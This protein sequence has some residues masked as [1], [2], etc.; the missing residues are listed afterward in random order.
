MAC[1]SFARPWPPERKMDHRWINLEERKEAERRKRRR[2]FYLILLI[3]LFIVGITYLEVHLP[4]LKDQVPIGGNVLFFTIINVNLILFLLLIFLVI[5]NL[6]KLMLE[7]KRRLLGS[8]LKTKLSLAFIFLSLVP[9]LLLFFTSA[10]FITRSVESWFSSQVERSLQ[11]S[12]EVAQLYYRDFAKYAVHHSKR[13]GVALPRKGK[14]K[15]VLERKRK[16]YGLDWVGVFD[17]K[18]KLLTHVSS[19]DLPYVTS[20]PEDFLAEVFKGKEASWVSPFYTS[21]MIWGGSVAGRGRAVVVGYY[22]PQNLVGKMKEIS[23]AF[24]NYRQSQALK[25]PLITNYLLVLLLIT[26][27]IIF[28]ATWFGFRLAKEIT[29]PIER[30]A[31][32]TKRIASGDLDFRLETESRDEIGAL[33]EAFNRMTE[34]LSASHTALQKANLELEAR[35]RYIEIVLENVSAGVISFDKEG[36]I[37][38]VNKAAEEMLEV[39]ASE[40]VGRY[41]R[42]VL[43]PEYRKIAREMIREINTTRSESLQKQMELNLN[44]KVITVR[45]SVNLMRD[46]KGEYMG[47]VAV[48]DDLTHLVKMERLTAWREVAKRIAHEIKNPLTPIQLSAQRIYKRYRDRIKGDTAVFQECTNTIIQQ[49]N[50][51][52]NLVNEFTQFARMPNINPTPNDLNEVISEGLVLY[53][54][55]HKDISFRFTPEPSLPVFKFDREQIKRVMINLLDNAVAAVD[56]KGEVDVE[57]RYN[58]SLRMATIEVRDNGC[59]IPDEDKAKLFEPYFSTKK[60]GTGLGLAIVN[61]IIADHNGFIRV[62]DNEP[63]GTRFIIELPVRT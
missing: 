7:R 61:T 21:E 50:E 15:A 43:R 10:L 39:R 30:L 63:K 49:V 33:V 44:G 37:T 5:R 55:A 23:E 1:R 36:R 53:K 14:L 11:G 42:N 54:E 17:P 45:V 58:P 25:R 34:Q 51:L 16:E 2:E 9:T 26:L 47:M 32:G 62:R 27:L 38:T 59:G 56:G 48:F 46:E 18:G 12:L 19:E 13:I 60:T 6:V 3:A 57:V 4:A 24:V 8:Q 20:P 31:E 35:K 29:I 52:K 28:S 41:Y 40:V 22:I